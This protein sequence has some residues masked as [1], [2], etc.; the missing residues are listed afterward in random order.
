ARDRLDLPRW[1]Q[2]SPQPDARPSKGRALS[3]SARAGAVRADP[4]RGR[5]RAHRLCLA[6]AARPDA[7][8]GRPDLDNR[9]AF[10]GALPG[11]PLSRV[12]A[13]TV[14]DGPPEFSRIIRGHA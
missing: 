2:F 14:R 7:G 3:G 8:E 10:D 12:D 13:A 9:P 1:R 11:I 6:V 5:A 4:R